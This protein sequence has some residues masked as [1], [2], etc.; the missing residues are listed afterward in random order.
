[1]RKSNPVR[2]QYLL[3]GTDLIRAGIRTLGKVTA[4]YRENDASGVIFSMDPASERWVTS[5]AV[6]SACARL[7]QPADL[8]AVPAA[9][10]LAELRK[11]PKAKVRTTEDHIVHMLGG[12]TE[13]NRKFA[14]SQLALLEATYLGSSVQAA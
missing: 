11:D 14:Q 7:G 1:M 9:L 5:R 10:I 4:F 6:S 12:E 13:A 2:G 3:V 8:A